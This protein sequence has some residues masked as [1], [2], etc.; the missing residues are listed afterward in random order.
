M[1]TTQQTLREKL[2]TAILD[3]SGDEFD[4]YDDFI[5]LAKKSEEQLDDDLIHIADYYKTQE[6]I[7]LNH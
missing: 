5:K 4:N 1:K 6:D 3:L 7:L 2:I